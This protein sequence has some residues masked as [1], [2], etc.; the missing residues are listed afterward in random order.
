MY[1]YSV[2]L[3]RK[4]CFDGKEKGK[5]QKRYSTGVCSLLWHC[6]RG[7]LPGLSYVARYIRIKGKT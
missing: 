2:C 6:L 3:W 7:R 5:S 4:G 1:E